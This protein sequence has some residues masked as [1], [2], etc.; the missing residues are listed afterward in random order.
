[1]NR[2]DEPQ[3]PEEDRG[4]TTPTPEDIKWATEHEED[5]EENS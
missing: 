2:Y 3:E 1:M 5:I 4:Y